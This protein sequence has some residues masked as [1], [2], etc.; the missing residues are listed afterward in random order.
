MSATAICEDRLEQIR[1][2]ARQDAAND[3]PLPAHVK[4][5][6]STIL[7]PRRSGGGSR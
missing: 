2:R 4:D 5:R 7:A 3:P 1:Q 6:I